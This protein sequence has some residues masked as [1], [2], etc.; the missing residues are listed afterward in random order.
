MPPRVQHAPDRMKRLRCVD[1]CLHVPAVLAVA[2][3]AARVVCQNTAL[4]SVPQNVS[5][6]AV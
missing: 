2:R 1:D 4:S 6:V 5:V 3:Q